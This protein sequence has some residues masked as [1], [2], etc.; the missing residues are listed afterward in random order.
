MQ[1][2]SL[3]GV[4]YLFAGSIIPRYR[5][6]EVPSTHTAENHDFI[7]SNQGMIGRLWLCKAA[8]SDGYLKTTLL[9][10]GSFTGMSVH[11]TAL[12]ERHCDCRCKGKFPTLLTYTIGIDMRNHL[13][14]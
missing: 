9:N 11:S 10:E 1:I 2:S 12:C 8:G 6:V 14:V 4:D 13:V 3:E 5:K 7:S